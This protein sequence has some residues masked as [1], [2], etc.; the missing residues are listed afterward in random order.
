[1][2][3]MTKHL[4]A[5]EFDKVLELLAV[6]GC[7]DDAKE[8]I[9]N[10]R[11]ETDINKALRLMKMTEDAYLQ[12]KIRRSHRERRQIVDYTQW[13]FRRMASTT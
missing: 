4:K 2:N 12:E 1:M 11:P 8:I 9:M 13:P 5:L 3:G 10:L 6:R 7:N